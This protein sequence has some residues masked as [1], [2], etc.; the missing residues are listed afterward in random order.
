MYTRYKATYMFLITD[1][2]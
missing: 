2:K 1:L